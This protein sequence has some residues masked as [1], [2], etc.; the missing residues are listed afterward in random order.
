MS[1][2]GEGPIECEHSARCPGCTQL[3][4]TAATRLMRK[5]DA[6]TIAFGRYPWLRSLTVHDVAGAQPTLGYRTRAKLVA[7]EH[8]HIGLYARGSHDVVDIPH[9]RVLPASIADTIARLRGL[10][11]EAGGALSAVDVREV[12]TANSSAVL[13]TLIGEERARVALDKLAHALQ[14][15]PHVLGVA[16][17]VRDRR[18]PTVLG[19]TPELISGPSTVRETL[20]AS[21]LYQLVTHGSFVQAHREQAAALTSRLVQS[22][23]AC[24][25][26]L[27]RR[28][29]LELYAGSGALALQLCQQGARVVANERFEPAL[30]RA[31]QAAHEQSLSGLEV[32]AGDAADVSESLARRAQRFDGVIVNPPRRGL[33]L[34][35]RSALAALA[36]AAIAYVSCDPE[37]LAR[38]LNHFALLGFAAS[39]V[40]PYDMI[41]LSDAV[42]S[43][44][45]L[46]PTPAPA[47]EVLY[48]DEA[49]IAVEKPPHLPTIPQGESSRSLLEAV[50]DQRRLPGLA[51]IHRLDQGSSGICLLAKRPDAVAGFADA[52]RGGDKQYTALARGVTRGKGSV[53][54]PLAD[55]PVRRDARTRYQRLAVMGGHSLL[56][57]RPDQ[58]RKHQIRRH[59]AAIGH[60]LLGDPRYGDA[61]SN[62]HF[63]L[64]HGLDRAFLHLSRIE[65]RHPTSGATLCIE[66]PLAGDLAMVC[67]R[68]AETTSRTSPW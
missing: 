43:L 41:P 28:R 25:G 35:L 19:G 56:R 20:P 22:L 27:A 48:E 67:E 32:V 7:D 21:E 55:G 8:G 3:G 51:A 46:T 2:P 54:R 15:T 61:A 24:L 18:A 36:P 62:R 68:L 40:H 33:P 26:G 50:R 10:A 49:L 45:L 17:S 58:G 5:R 39:Q 60:P 11:R 66:S 42:E 29:V 52:L 38:D 6:V 37:T 13:V 16:R 31:A 9:C 23:G 57:V 59:L 1:A 4:L 63:E 53:N 30:Q 34:R 12:R 65:L 47:I 64:R 44:V 14:D